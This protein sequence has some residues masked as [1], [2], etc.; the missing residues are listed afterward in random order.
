MTPLPPAWMD[1]VLSVLLALVLS[2]AIARTYA[3]TYRGL[4]YLPEFT[5]A[6]ALGGVVSA[7]VLL[8][9]GDEVARGIGLMGALTLI[10]FRSTLKDPRDLIFAFASL[11]SGVACG[12]RAYAAALATT[13]VFIAASAILARSSFGERRP[14]DAVLRLQAPADGGGQPALDAVL[15]RYCR[16]FALVQMHAADEDRQ[17][18]LYHLRLGDAERRTGLVRDLER[19]DGVGRV[20]LLLH[21]GAL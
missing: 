20:S 21:E 8:A 4:S 5:Q 7:G 13:A 10:R 11:G 15:R 9:I 12:A 14:F 19:V 2:V 16:D 18:H 3:S 1:T 6:L 17:E